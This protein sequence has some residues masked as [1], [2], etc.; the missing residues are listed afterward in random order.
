MAEKEGRWSTSAITRVRLSPG[1]CLCAHTCPHLTV[2]SD[3]L[4]VPPHWLP[5]EGSERSPG[6]C[7]PTAWIPSGGSVFFSFRLPL[8]FFPLTS[9]LISRLC[10]FFCSQHTFSCPVSFSLLSQNLL[11]IL[12]LKPIIFISASDPFFFSLPLSHAQS[13]TKHPLSEPVPLLCPPPG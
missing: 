1:S 6:I 9:L 5:Q 3:P 11:L 7:T 2:A 13:H 4:P 12:A 10:L 8:V